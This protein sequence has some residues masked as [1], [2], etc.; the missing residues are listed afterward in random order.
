MIY[1]SKDATFG[2]HVQIIDL[3][4]SEEAPYG[5]MIYISDLAHIHRDENVF[6]FRKRMFIS[7]PFHPIL[8]HGMVS[9][10]P[11]PACVRAF[12][13]G[14]MSVR[15]H[16]CACACIKAEFLMAGDYCMR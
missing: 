16:V 6:H 11:I 7:S 2:H 14:H 13:R 1:T 10:H 9:R 4:P 12:V 3:V 15:V 8:S 5:K